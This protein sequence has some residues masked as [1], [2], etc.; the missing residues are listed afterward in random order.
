MMSSSTWPVTVEV[1]VL[2]GFNDRL[3]DIVQMVRD[4]LKEQCSFFSNGPVE[5]SGRVADYVVS[6]RVVDMPQ[7]LSIS[8]WQA[9]LFVHAYVMLQKGSKKDYLDENEQ[10]DLP[11][12]EEWQLPNQAFD[13]LWDSIVVNDSIKRKLLGYCATSAQFSEA[14]VDSNII[15]WNRMALLNGPPGT[16]KTT[17]C[18]ALAHKIAIR[19]AKKFEECL[20]LEINAHA[21]FSKWF[22]ES[23]KLVQ[24]LFEQIEAITDDHNTLVTVLIDEVESIASSRTASMTTSEPG[25]AVRVVNSVLTCLD[26]LRRRPNVLILTTSNIVGSI[27]AAFRDRIDICIFLDTPSIHA[28]YRILWTCL[29]E[30]MNKGIIHSDPTFPDSVSE[31]VVRQVS[32]AEGAA[33]LKNMEDGDESDDHSASGGDGGVDQYTQEDRED[34]TAEVALASIAAKCE[35]L[36]GRRLRKLPLLAHAYYV[37]KPAASVREF[38]AATEHA[39]IDI[40]Q[41]DLEA[42]TLGTKV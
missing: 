6:V 12:Y 25:D 3:D 13:G 41:A 34:F 32:A 18:K 19:N 16:G 8:F 5:V 31:S 28:R 30:L 7:S 15:S 39:I 40:L 27:D 10:G 26:T 36:S 9:I 11:A 29:Q 1:Q 35:G 22:S 23:G 14:E 42:D 37:C 2:E 21:L 33:E 20:L 4:F 38:L 17:L 24:A